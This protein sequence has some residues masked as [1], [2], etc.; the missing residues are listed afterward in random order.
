MAK[1]SSASSRREKL[2]SYSAEDILNRPLSKRQRRDLETLRDLPDSKIDTSD[3][4]ELTDEQ[5]AALGR[6]REPKKLI[7][8][9]LDVDVVAWLKTLGLG[10]SGYS[11]HINRILRAVMEQTRSNAPAAPGLPSMPAGTKVAAR[12]ASAP[13]PRPR[14]RSA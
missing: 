10:E 3:I 7:A 14:R 9:R 11:S 1:K 6:G 5:L 12:A 13:V 2:V 4:P 8:A